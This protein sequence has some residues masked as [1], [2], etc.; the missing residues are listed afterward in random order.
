MRSA[1]RPLLVVLG[2]SAVTA[3]NKLATADKLDTPSIPT[4]A[5]YVCA[6]G[7][8]TNRT[9]AAIELA[10]NV[11]ALCRR[12]PEMGPCQYARNACRRSG[13][14]VYSADGSEITQADEADYDKKVMRV[15]VGP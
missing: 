13:G 10:E 8:G 14:R 15:R 11:A 5:V 7:S 1:L 2:V 6:T 9:I 12:H 3:M 4:G